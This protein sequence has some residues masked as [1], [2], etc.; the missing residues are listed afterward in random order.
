MK[1]QIVDFGIIVLTT[2]VRFYAIKRFIDIFFSKEECRCKHTWKL[3]VIACAWTCLIYGAFMQP[4]FNIFSNMT[5]IFLLVIPYRAKMSKKILMTLLIYAINGLVDSV[6]VILFTEYKVGD[7][8]AP[9]YQC[10]TSLV[11][12]VI[13]IALE[14]TISVEGEL[15]LPTFYV[16]IL[17]LVP[18]ISI[19]CIYYVDITATELKMTVVFVAVSI[20]FIDILIFYLYNSLGAFYSAHVEKK[21]LEQLVEVYANQLNVVHESQEQVNSLRHDMKHHIIELSSMLSEDENPEAI[22]YLKDMEKFMLNPKEHVS[23]GNKE[24]DGVLNYLL[25]RAEHTITNTDIRISIPDRIYLKKF[26]I[27]AILGNLVDN[28]IREADKTTEKYLKI[29]IQ[30]KKGIMLIYIEN[31]YLGEVVEKK[32]MF[33]TTQD[34]VAIHGIGLKNVK[35]IVESNGGELDIDYFENRFKVR[36]L[37]YLE[38]MK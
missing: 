25:Q 20:L 11:I 3:Y 12:M 18:M 38:S 23:T 36:V 7:M 29:D 15:R 26:D 10:I 33:K 13:A 35:K 19:G 17:G 6:I 28:A 37:L 34:E 14:R 4:I 32:Y 5:A 30:V 8:V 1:F 16:V 24:I 22:Q 31:S 9:V 2:I 21:M 27:C